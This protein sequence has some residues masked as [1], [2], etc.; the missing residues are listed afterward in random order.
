MPKNKVISKRGKQ[1][2]PTFRAVAQ[3]GWPP[4][5]QTLS[6]GELRARKFHMLKPVEADF[7]TQAA[8]EQLWRRGEDV[9]VEPVN[10]KLG[11]EFTNTT[12]VVLPPGRYWMVTLATAWI[13]TSVRSCTATVILSPVCPKRATTTVSWAPQRLAM[14]V[15]PAQTGL[16]TALIQVAL[17]S[18]PPA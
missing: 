13:V 17:V 8:W 3:V 14:E 1:P 10:S 11:W 5:R 6:V 9:K 4:R 12:R 7:P 2:K 18:S 15:T 16:S